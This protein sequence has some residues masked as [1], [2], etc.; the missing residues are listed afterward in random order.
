M[1]PRSCIFLYPVSGERCSE[2]IDGRRTTRMKNSNCI[3]KNA[4][5]ILALVT[6]IGFMVYG[7]APAYA[8]E[9]WNMIWQKA[10]DI[11]LQCIGLG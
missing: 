7:C 9:E 5:W 4:A 6:A 3:L 11:C 10:V 1:Q 2:W 8:R